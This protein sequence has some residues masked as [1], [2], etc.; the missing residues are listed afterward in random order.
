MAVERVLLHRK[1]REATLEIVRHEG[2]IVLLPFDSDGKLLLVRQYRQRGRPVSV[3]GSFLP[4]VL[5]T[6]EDPDHAARRE[7]SGRA[8]G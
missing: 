6:G 2:S 7:W 3:G 5:E 1:G 8:P 4:G